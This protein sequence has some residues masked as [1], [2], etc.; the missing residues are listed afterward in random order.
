MRSD[1]ANPSAIPSTTSWR[2]LARRM[3]RRD[4][5]PRSRSRATTFCRLRPTYATIPKTVCPDDAP[6]GIE[7]EE[8]PPGHVADPG[9]P[10]HR[11]PETGDEARDRRPSSRRAARRTP[12]PAAAAGRGRPPTK[13]ILS[14]SAPTAHAARSSSPCCRRRSP[15][16]RPRRSPRRCR[17]V[18]AGRRAR[19]RR[20]GPFRPGAG[21]PQPS[22]ATKSEQQDEAVALEFVGHRTSLGLTPP[23]S[24]DS[25]ARP[26]SIASRARMRVGVPK[27]TAPGERGSAL[28]PDA[29]ARLEGSTIVVERGAGDG[30]RLSGR[31]LRRGGRRARRRRLRRASMPSS[32]SPARPRPRPTASTSGQLLVAFLQPLTD[33]KAD[34]R[35]LRERR[36]PRVRDGVDPAHDPRTGDGRALVAGDGLRLQGGAARAPSG[37]RGSSRC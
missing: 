29:S 22:M 1:S 26:F 25:A 3:R 14:S 21:F 16:P 6:G 36:R 15:R 2:S 18:T 28:V 20:S 13:G 37:C 5:D 9:Q 17:I 33:P 34:R 35:G 27:E 12:R 23:P 31:R 10:G 4:S 7:G 19:P 32:R 8:T 30:R 11:D 24:A